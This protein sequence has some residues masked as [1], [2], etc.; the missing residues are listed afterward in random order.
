MSQSS[1]A[2]L[3]LQEQDDAELMAAWPTPAAPVSSDTPQA[4]AEPLPF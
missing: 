1:T 4:A 3:A 2:F